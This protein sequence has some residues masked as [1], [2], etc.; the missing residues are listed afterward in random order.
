MDKARATAGSAALCLSILASSAT[1]GELL[2]N[3]DFETG[4]LTGWTWVPTERPEPMLTTEVVGFDT[5]GSG[6]SLAFRVNPGRNPDIGEA[7]PEGG[8]LTQAVSMAR[9]IEY[10]VR[11]RA[12][13]RTMLT[14][15]NG[16]GGSISVRI[17]GS[18]LWCWS[19]GWMEGETTLRESFAGTYTPSFT[20]LHNLSLTFLR[21]AGNY[22]TTP[23]PV[24][25]VYH[26]VDNVS[27]VPEP[28]TGLLLVFG[29][30]G[31]LTR[32]RRRRR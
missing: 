7:Q 5:S 20:G 25:R 4:D 19:V 8:S 1:A 13:I 29:A 21:S 3:G 15:P 31:L 9:G 17:D 27:V 12:A 14:L 22:G 18:E 10:E 30:A 6:E 16:E 32:K 24:P 26:Y 2:V 11:G 28:A 23:Y